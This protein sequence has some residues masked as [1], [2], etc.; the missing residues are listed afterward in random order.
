MRSGQFQAYAAV[1]DARMENGQVVRVMVYFIDYR[2]SIYHFV[3]YTAPQAFG[4]FRSVFLQTMQGFGEIQDP[5]ILNRRAGSPGAG[6]RLAPGALRR[7][8]PQK[9]TRSVQARRRRAFKS[10]QFEGRNRAGKNLKVPGVACE[11]APEMSKL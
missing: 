1:A 5:R 6:N 7:I 11:T 8:N 2:G 10:S 4:A 9:L 3:G